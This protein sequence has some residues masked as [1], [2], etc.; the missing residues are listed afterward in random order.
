MK[1]SIN[2]R[3]SLRNDIIIE[4]VD[5]DIKSYYNSHISQ[6]LEGRLKMLSGGLEDLIKDQNLTL[7]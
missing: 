4:L 6:K 5:K 7:R 3:N 2:Q 1:N